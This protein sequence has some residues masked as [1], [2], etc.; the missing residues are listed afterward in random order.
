MS[1]P[2]PVSAPTPAPAPA[3]IVSGADSARADIAAKSETVGG[4][5]NRLDSWAVAVGDWRVSAFDI[6]FA[7]VAVLLVLAIAW[8]ATRLTRSALRRLTALD[9]TQRVLTEKIATIIIWVAAFFVGVDLLGIDL[10]ALTVFSGAFGLAIGFGLQKTFGNLISGIILLMD[11]SIKPGD[12]IAVSDMAGNHTFGQI[13]KIGIRAVSVT[14]R[15]EREYLIPNENLMINQVENWSYSSKN[16]RFQVNVGV[17]YDADMELAEKLML[18]AAKKARRV[19][20]TP[21]PTVWMSEYGDSSVNFTIHCWITDPEDGVGNVR[22]EVLK[23]LWWLFKENGIEIPF[24]QR[25]INLRD[26]EQMKALIA[27]LES[28]KQ[29]DEPSI[30]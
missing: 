4:I 3:E 2:S 8:F 9:G 21:P 11:K 6:L 27:A 19:L 25:D 22:S 7:L 1:T 18:E 12:V 26:N 14:T 17:S 15:D 28:R 10:T 20:D 29:A 13:R 5:I 16:V 30:R 24:P 23:N